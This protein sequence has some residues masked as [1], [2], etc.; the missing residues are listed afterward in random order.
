MSALIYTV[1][2][3]RDD[4]RGVASQLLDEKLVACANVIGKVEALFEWDGERGEGEEIGVL[5]KTH[6]AR[7]DAAVSRLEQ[8][9]PYDTPAILGW[10]ADAS[11]A[12]TSAWLAALAD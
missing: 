6:A 2:A 10:R 5:F 7:L 12:A 11:G 8:V 9:H 4:A 3:S 1:F